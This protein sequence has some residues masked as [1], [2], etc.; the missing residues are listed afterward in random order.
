MGC[1]A[2]CGRAVRFCIAHLTVAAIFTRALGRPNPPVRPPKIPSA[3]ALIYTH[4]HTHTR[5]RAYT[6]VEL[7][8]TR[9]VYLGKTDAGEYPLAKKKQ[10]FEYLREKAHLRPRCVA[11]CGR[12]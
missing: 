4:S 2:W 12:E 6:Q 9:V 10:T 1:R 8:A 3:A 7:K 5:T 11:A